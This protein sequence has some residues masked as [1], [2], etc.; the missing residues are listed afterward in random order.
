MRAESLQTALAIGPN[1]DITGH[2]AP[3]RQEVEWL[4]E[5]SNALNL[6]AKGRSSIKKGVVTKSAWDRVAAS[7]ARESALWVLNHVVM[8]A[9]LSDRQSIC[10]RAGRST[11]MHRQFRTRI[12]RVLAIL[13]SRP[14]VFRSTLHN[15]VE[16]LQSI[17]SELATAEKLERVNDDAEEASFYSAAGTPVPSSSHESYEQEQE[18]PEEAEEEEEEEEEYEDEEQEEEEDEEAEQEEE[19]EQVPMQD[20]EEQQGEPMDQEDE[21]EEEGHS[22]Q[23]EPEYVMLPEKQAEA[24][25]TAAPILASSASAEDKASTSIETGAMSDIESAA[26]WQTAQFS[27]KDLSLKCTHLADLVDTDMGEHVDD[28]PDEAV[29]TACD[30]LRLV[31]STEC[32]QPEKQALVRVLDRAVRRLALDALEHANVNTSKMFNRQHFETRGKFRLENERVHPIDDA[33]AFSVGNAVA[34]TH[35]NRAFDQ[36]GRIKTLLFRRALQL[37]GSDDCGQFRHSL[38]QLVRK[39]AHSLLR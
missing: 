19:Y 30:T 13:I 9:S 23:E 18:Q 24:A 38:A 2:T 10:A 11:S 27:A 21:Y 35:I 39:H 26:E 34:R 4:R 32:C 1:E 3:V 15:V 25:A 17:D 8:S 36:N 6:A 28:L 20:D 22:E 29:A 7:M 31:T 37:P 14:D 16:L 12:G 5:L 33:Y